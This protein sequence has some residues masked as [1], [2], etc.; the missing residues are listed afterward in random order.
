MKKGSIV[1]LGLTPIFLGVIFYFLGF[2]F[3]ENTF[4]LNILS[5][6]FMFFWAYIGFFTYKENRNIKENMIFGNIMGF[7]VIL[8]AVT[9][10]YA[11]PP[12]PRR[13]FLPQMFFLPIL[14]LL[15]PYLQVSMEGLILIS[16]LV[17]IL[18]FY[19]G[20]FFAKKNL[21]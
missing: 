16:Y 18:I 9:N 15:N 13:L 19:I 21:N 20:N 6:S 7:I 11:T 4:I 17:N 3:K 8:F 12:D 1:K 10:I 5:V 2:A 14:N